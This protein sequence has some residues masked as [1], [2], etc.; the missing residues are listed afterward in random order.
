VIGA[1]RAGKQRE[2]LTLELGKQSCDV[3]EATW[4]KYKD[5][6]KAKVSVRASSGDIVCDSL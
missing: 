6:D 5:G 3:S 4:R 1:R 2:T